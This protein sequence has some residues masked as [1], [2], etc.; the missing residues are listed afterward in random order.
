MAEAIRWFQIGRP[1]RRRPLTEQELRRLIRLG[2]PEVA[3]RAW[4]GHCPRCRM[5]RASLTPRGCH[6]S[7]ELLDLQL[8]LIPPTRP[9]P[10]PKRQARKPGP[11]FG[12]PLPQSQKRV[13]DRMVVRFVDPAELRKERVT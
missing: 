8:E 6:R 10:Q 9:A 13:S 12:R 2:F 7:R 3:L 4:A 11:R 5:N 1:A